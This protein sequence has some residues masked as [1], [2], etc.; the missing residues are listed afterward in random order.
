MTGVFFYVYK[1]TLS[2]EAS[3]FAIIEKGKEMGLR[4]K[5]R[6]CVD[7]S[8]RVELKGWLVT[9]MIFEAFSKSMCVL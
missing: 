4:F 6:F 5:K 8:L 9:A 3:S 7:V 2:S 1:G